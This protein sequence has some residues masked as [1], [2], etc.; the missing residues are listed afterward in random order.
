LGLLSAATGD[1]RL[2]AETDDI[3]HAAAFGPDDD[4]YFLTLS[5][6]ALTESGIFRLSLGG[7]PPRLVVMTGQARSRDVAKELAVAPDG[8][9]VAVVDCSEG[10]CWTRGYDLAS[11]RQRW[12]A[13]TAGGSVVGADTA[14]LLLA[15]QCEEPCAVTKLDWLTGPGTAVGRTCVAAVAVPAQAGTALVTDV[16]PSGR[17]RSADYEVVAYVPVPGGFVSPVAGFPT[18]ERT[19]VA[20]DGQIGFELPPGWVVV[21]PR[22]APF[23]KEGVSPWFVDIDS[24]RVIRNE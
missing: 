7:G 6:D 9:A 4:V 14:G 15:R 10:T 2:L 1:D 12:S 8:S 19:L 18:R 13:A 22:G 17:C 3:I 11:G 21:G 24:R 16:A 23:P 5:P 20:R